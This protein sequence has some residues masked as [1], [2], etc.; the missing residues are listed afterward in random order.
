MSEPMGDSSI[1]ASPIAARRRHRP[2]GRQAA[3]E[4]AGLP[5]AA[6]RP[7]AAPRSG[8]A[9]DFRSA[10]LKGLYILRNRDLIYG[11]AEQGDISAIV[12]IYVPPQTTGSIAQSPSMLADA[13][14]I[15]SGW[16]G[17][18][19]DADFLAAA[20]R[21]KAVFYGAGSVRDIVTDAF[22]ARGVRITSAYAANAIP[23]AEYI[24]SQVLFCL[25]RGWHYVRAIRGGGQWWGRVP[26]PGAYGSTVGLVSMGVIGRL[27]LGL[28]RPFDLKLIGYRH[29]R[30]GPGDR[31]E[32]DRELNLELYTL[33]EVFRRSDV[34]SCHTPSLKA[35]DGMITGEHFAS[36]KHG[37]TF[38]NSARGSVVREDEMV[39]VL[40]R[41][42][43]LVAVLD[44]TDP[45]PPVSGSPLYELPNVV[46]T[47]HIAG[48][49]DGECRRMGRY[50]V[51]ELGRFCD[52]RP[53]K[54]E[55]TRQQH[56]AGMA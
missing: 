32:L 7:A 52:G 1:A 36:M 14:V 23:V 40:R 30:G 42:D 6:F 22:W 17:P 24:L 44:V 26:T 48:S 4:T 47:P 37:A 49:L 46:L 41:R 33:E 13:E 31:A 28:L 54:W 12:D 50:M 2:S 45:E 56:A 5:R 19:I 38:I 27:A 55:I 3:L 25:K 35:T 9:A 43:D 8:A 29:G 34:V 21:L 11:P 18:K 16:G 10:M 20:P 39:E 53:L 51:E 15:F